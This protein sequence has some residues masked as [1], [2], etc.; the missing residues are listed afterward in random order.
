MS[1]PALALRPPLSKT[2]PRAAARILAVPFAVW[3]SLLL[4]CA[5]AVWAVSLQNIDIRQINDLGLV[6][7][8]PPAFYVSIGIVCLAFCLALRREPL[9]SLAL[10][11]TILTLIVMLYGAASLIEPE[12]RFQATYKHIGIV[13]HI[14]RYGTVDPNIDAYFNWPVF[15]VWGALLT[16]VAGLASPMALTSWTPVV[17]NALYLAPL[18]LIFRAG[19]SNQRLVWVACWF[20]FVGNWIGQDYFSPQ[21]LNFFLYLAVLAIVLTWFKTPSIRQLATVDLSLIHI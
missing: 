12:P 2:G 18:L 17:L 13:Q 15:F 4:A 10:A 1:I 20:F 8:L 16:Q 6:S 14:I 7:V 11:A 21:G 5:V 3:Y 19:S 9:N